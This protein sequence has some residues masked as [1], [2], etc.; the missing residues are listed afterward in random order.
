L[1]ELAGFMGV[2]KDRLELKPLPSEYLD[3]T[4]DGV[5]FK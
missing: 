1:H 2:R 3:L 5:S 4:T